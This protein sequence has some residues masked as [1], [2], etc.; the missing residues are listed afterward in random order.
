MC[1]VAAIWFLCGKQNVH[2]KFPFQNK[3]QFSLHYARGDTDTA[4]VT[5]IMSQAC[6]QDNGFGGQLPSAC[7]IATCLTSPYIYTGIAFSISHIHCLPTG[8]WSSNHPSTRSEVLRKSDQK[9]EHAMWSW[10]ADKTRMWLQ[11]LYRHVA[12][13]SIHGHQVHAAMLWGKVKQ[14]RRSK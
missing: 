9:R 7:P 12:V 1:L 6:G 4:S 13:T 3:R 14:N 2:L 8:R 10:D 11:I 5:C